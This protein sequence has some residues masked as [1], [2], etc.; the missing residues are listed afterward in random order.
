MSY[1]LYLLRFDFSVLNKFSLSPFPV[2]LFISYCSKG[3]SWFQKSFKKVYYYLSVK[4]SYFYTLP[5]LSSRIPPVAGEIYFDN[6]GN[7]V[8]G[9]VLGLVYRIILCSLLCRVKYIFARATLRHKCN[10]L[11][12]SK[13]VPL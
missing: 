2:E 7:Q 9:K 1:D 5:Y 8:N 12:S 4:T 11:L 3:D 13:P 10:K 6:I